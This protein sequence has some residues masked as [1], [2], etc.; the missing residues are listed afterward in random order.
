MKYI[1]CDESC[2]LENDGNDIMVLGAMTVPEEHKQRIFEEIRD[3]KTK[4]GISSW[5]EVKWTKVSNNKINFYKELVNYYF[6][7]PHLGFRSVVAKGKTRLDYAAFNHD[8]DLWYYKMYFLL[9]NQMIYPNDNYRI[10][11]DIKDTNGGEKTRKLHEVLCNN[12]YDFNR[13]LINDLQQIHSNE[14]EVLQLCDLL[15]GALSFYHRGLYG[16]EGASTAKNQLVDEL[17]RRTGTDLNTTTS[18]SEEKFNLFIWEP[19]GVL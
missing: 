17:M 3:I 2:H 9:L 12:A 19:R 14:S 5:L 1:Y 18:L 13:T 10:F 4:N 7:E 16:T 11:L 8:H 6:E 15:I